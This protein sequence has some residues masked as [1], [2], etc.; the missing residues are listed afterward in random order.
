MAFV[1]LP[2]NLQD[3]FYALSDRIAKLETGPN[4]AMYVAESAQGSSSQASTEAAQALSVA[5]EAQIQAINAGIQANTAAS[6]ATIAQA[7]ATIASSQATQ[8]Q[9][10][11]NG[12]NTVYYGTASTPGTAT[13]T[14]ASGNGTTVT[15]TAYNGFVVGQTVTVSGIANI[16]AN[17]PTQPSPLPSPY[18]LTGVITSASFTQFSIASTATGSYTSGG[19]ANISGL[20]Y[21]VGDLYFQYNTSSQVIAQY[22]WNGSAWQ[23]TPITNTVITN[24]DAGKITT[25]ILNAIQIQAG[26]GGQYFTVSP[27]GYMSAQGVYVRGNITADSG[28]FTGTIQASAG[29]FGN[30]AGGNY[31][32]IGSSGL[33]AVGTGTITGGQINGSSIYIGSGS[34]VFSVTAAGV[35]SATGANISGTIAAGSGNIGGW[36][37]NSI[38][39]YNSAAT[40]SI[41]ASDGSIVST[42]TSYLK[43]LAING[44]TIATYALAVSGN[45]T[46][47]GDMT[48][49]G[50]I[51]AQTN[52]NANGS[53]TLG[54]SNQF[55]YLSS[56]GTLRSVYTYGKAVTGR[57]MQINSAGDFGTTASTLRK[58][59]EV[60]PYAIDTSKLLQ[61]QPKTFKYLPEIDQHQEQQYGFIAEEAEALGLLP[62]VLYNEQGQVDYFAYEKLPIFLLQLAQEQEARIQALEGN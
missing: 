8:A 42:G 21:K 25:G 29:Y 18:N 9:A 16:P 39:L 59:H 17:P 61:L 41:N 36:Y 3:M 48:A 5:T 37:F 6:Q 30:Y 20:S 13:V 54:T 14:N 22:S 33:T 7:Q 4:Q 35:M 55:Q 34:T 53:M 45:S 32:S 50:T 28:T 40:A 38:G 11:A 43:A 44:A 52:L 15:Y 24:L 56:S 58:K 46:F 51:T 49:T 57:A 62:L 26:S 12:K 47:T 60:E 10:S 23:S 27:S 1:N 19:T 31:W 2:P